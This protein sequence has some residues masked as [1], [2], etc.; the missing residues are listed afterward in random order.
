MKIGRILSK[1][2]LGW[3]FWITNRNNKLAQERLAICMPC[4]YREGK[5]CGSCG[6]LLSAKARLP[7]EQCPYSKWLAVGSREM[8]DCTDHKE[9]YS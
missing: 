6:C 5:F 7:E 2:I 9:K 1:I 8:I 3:W 4:Q